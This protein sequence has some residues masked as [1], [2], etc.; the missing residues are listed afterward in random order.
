MITST[1]LATGV[2][3]L[4]AV[5][6]LWGGTNPLLKRGAKG[7]ETVRG[8]GRLRQLFAE[9]CFLVSNPRYMVPFVLNQSGSLLY[10]FTLGSADLSVAVPLTNSLTFVFTLIT[11]KLLGENIGGT[12]A[13]LGMLLMGVGLTLCVASNAWREETTARAS[14]D[15]NAADVDPDV[16]VSDVSIRVAGS[17]FGNFLA[18]KVLGE[19]RSVPGEARWHV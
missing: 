7:V 6:L 5:A 19:R 15:V 4:T 1:L 12:R 13:L 2:L 9:L 16:V 11:G 18:P 14:D 17:C 8:R 10:Y 3:W